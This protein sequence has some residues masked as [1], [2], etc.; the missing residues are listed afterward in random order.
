MA[1]G[2]QRQQLHAAKVQ[3][4]AAMHQPGGQSKYAQ[5]KLR[6]ARGHYAPTSPFYLPP[7]EER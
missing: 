7:E 5:K 4:R 1:K 2:K 6:N 3:R